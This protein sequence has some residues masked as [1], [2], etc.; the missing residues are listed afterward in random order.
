MIRRRLVFN[1]VSLTP[2]DWRFYLALTV[3]ILL[4]ILFYYFITGIREVFRHP[5]SFEYPVFVPLS[6][7]RTYLYNFFF[8]FL[9]STVGVIA[10]TKMWASANLAIPGRIRSS[11]AVDQQMVPGYFI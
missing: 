4:T 10:F 6:P 7:L 5:M 9:S 2:V 3:G 8:A 1:K 11:I